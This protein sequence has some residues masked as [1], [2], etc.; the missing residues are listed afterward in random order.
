MYITGNGDKIR[1]Y[2]CNYVFVKYLLLRKMAIEL[3][4]KNICKNNI[5]LFCDGA[6]RNLQINVGRVKASSA[7][8]PQHKI[9]LD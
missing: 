6:N 8:F 1:V 7:Q 9:K 3:M 4:C 2:T 5:D